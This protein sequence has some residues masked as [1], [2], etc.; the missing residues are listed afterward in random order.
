MADEKQ[1]PTY[2]LIR[3]D[4]LRRITE[5]TLEPGQS[6]PSE[7]DMCLTYDT[8]RMT[9][10]QAIGELELQGYV[11]R[12]QGKGTFVASQKVIQPLFHIS[13][14]TED[15]RKRGK[16]PQSRVLFCGTLK[17]DK[18]TA[19]RLGIALG[20]AYVCVKRLRLADEVPMAVETSC[21][22][23]DL[24]SRVLDYDLEQNS[25][26]QILTSVVGLSL[27]NG[28][29]YIEAGLTN[30][31][32]AVL[33]G[34]PTGSAALLIERHVLTETGVPVEVAHSVYRGD[35]YSFYVEFDPPEME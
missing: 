3:D 27:K 10:R 17:A 18:R 19:S 16:T 15:M 5:G 24:C 14:F 28:N 34:V 11:Y 22:R 33:L 4:M 7:R 6:L 8:S 32:Q 12:I 35:L 25:L 1:L 20:E 26:Y 9:V 29:Q 13:G 23:Y 31:A 2:K 30:E 21:L